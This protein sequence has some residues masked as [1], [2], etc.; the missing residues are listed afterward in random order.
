MRSI[1]NI[2]N[3]Q[4]VE[5][6]E[7][8][9]VIADPSKEQTTELNRQFRALKLLIGLVI[10]YHEVIVYL[11]LGNFSITMYIRSTGCHH[12]TK[13]EFCNVC[14]GLKNY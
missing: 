2:L 8:V 13:Q 14:L 11:I 10:I 5:A 3:K 1:N 4:L 6:V 12:F 9:E 7:A